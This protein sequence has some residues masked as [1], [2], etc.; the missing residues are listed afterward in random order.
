MKRTDL[1]SIPTIVGQFAYT[2]GLQKR[3]YLFF[4]LIIADPIWQYQVRWM[5]AA[6]SFLAQNR[7]ALQYIPR[8]QD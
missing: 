6:N 1:A 5:R 7:I 3:V 4:Q 8:L 2:V